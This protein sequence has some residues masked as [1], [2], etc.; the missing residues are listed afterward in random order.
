MCKLE[1]FGPIPDV[2]EAA[3]DVVKGVGGV[4]TDIVKGA[5]DAADS[6]GDA[7][8]RLDD[9]VNDITWRN[10]RRAEKAEERRYQL[11]RQVQITNTNYQKF[12][13]R[14]KRL[15]QIREARLRRAQA[16]SAAVASGAELG[17]SN[18][19]GVLGSLGTQTAFNE[20]KITNA[21]L[22]GNHLSGLNQEIGYQSYLFNKAQMN[23]QYQMQLFNTAMQVGPIAFGALK[24]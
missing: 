10:R 5:E 13:N 3:G 4:A 21:N 24:G 2:L 14:Q 7:F 8:A 11:Q 17:S 6:V 15:A 20:A 1:D 22:V 18:V 19:E 23:Q 12:N 16:I 9:F